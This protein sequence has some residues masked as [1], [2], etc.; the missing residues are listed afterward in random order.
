MQKPWLASYPAEVPHS[1]DTSQYG[2]LTQLLEDLA[3]RLPQVVPF[4][5]INVV[6]H[7]PARDVMRL[8]LALVLLRRHRRAGIQPLVAHTE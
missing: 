3:R 2:S 4:D 8:W 5:F 7:E 1:V 6:L